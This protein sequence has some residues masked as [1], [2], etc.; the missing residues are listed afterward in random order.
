MLVGRKLQIAWTERMVL[1]IE[2]LAL[3]CSRFGL[4]GE[5]DYLVY[6]LDRFDGETVRH[7]LGRP[8]GRGHGSSIGAIATA[9]NDLWFTDDEVASGYRTA[10]LGAGRRLVFGW[11]GGD[12]T[13]AIDKLVVPPSELGLSLDRGRNAVLYDLVDTGDSIVEREAGAPSDTRY[14]RAIDEIFEARGAWMLDGEAPSP[15]PGR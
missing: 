10:F 6:G 13:V 12:M 14:G 7:P 3:P 2:K 9:R 11:E 8:S 4:R 1:G 5:G 15:A